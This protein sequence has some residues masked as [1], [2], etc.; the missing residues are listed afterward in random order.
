MPTNCSLGRVYGFRRK[1][2]N[3]RCH[4][5]DLARATPRS[6]KASTIRWYGLS[7]S[8]QTR[9]SFPTWIN[10]RARISSK[11]G[12][13]QTGSPFAG[14]TTANVRSLSPPDAGEI[15]HRGPGLEDDRLGVRTPSSRPEASRCGQRNREIEAS[16][17]PNGRS[18]ARL[19]LVK[20]FGPVSVMYMQSSRRTPNSP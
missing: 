4:R 8:C 18:I 7:S 5:S 3:G 14:R 17:Y 13:T 19:C 2:R 6:F 1:R 9:M 16:R 20:N 10:S 12:S 11:P 15:K